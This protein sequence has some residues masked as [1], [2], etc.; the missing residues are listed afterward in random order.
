MAAHQAPPSLG[1]SRQKHWSGLPFPSPMTNLDNILKSRNSTLPTKVHLVKTMVFPLVIYGC[2]SCTTKKAEWRRIDAF[3][4]CCGERFLKVPWTARRSN[5]SILK[6]QGSLACCSP[7]DRKQSDTTERLSRTEHPHQSILLIGSKKSFENANGLNNS[8]N[9]CC[10]AWARSSLYLFSSSAWHQPL[11]GL[12]YSAI[13]LLIS[14]SLTTGPLFVMILLA[15]VFFDWLSSFYASEITLP[16][17]FFL[18]CLYL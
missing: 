1:F 5:Q 3:E 14:S 18:G 10:L 6:G 8:H 4:L 13:L 9:C 16:R 11:P 7:R 12:P 15:G 2:E 17:K